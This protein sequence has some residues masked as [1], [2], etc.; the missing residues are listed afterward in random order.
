MASRFVEA[1]EE[2]IEELKNT[3]EI[4][5]TTR[6]T[7]YWTDIFQQWAKTRGKMSNLKATKLHSLMKFSPNFLPSWGRE[8]VKSTNQTRSR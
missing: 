2:F 8:V 3:S 4:K 7:D 5:N 1:D 6:S